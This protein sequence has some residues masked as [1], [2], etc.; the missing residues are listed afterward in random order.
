MHLSKYSMNASIQKIAILYYNTNFTGSKQRN[1]QRVIM[2]MIFRDDRK[3]FSISSYINW[4]LH[5]DNATKSFAESFLLDNCD[6]VSLLF[7]YSLQN[8]LLLFIFLLT[9]PIV[10]NSYILAGIYFV[11][12]K[13]VLD[14]TLKTFDTKFGPQ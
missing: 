4:H 10:K 9:A 13:D 7:M 3:I 1:V 12:L 5:E 14:Q 2:M 6:Q 8:F 11:F